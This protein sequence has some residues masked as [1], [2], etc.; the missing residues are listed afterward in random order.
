MKVDIIPIGNSKGIRI[1][2]ALLDQCGFDK[3]VYIAV[4]DH[5]LILSSASKPRHGWDHAFKAMAAAKDDE[6]LELPVS[7]FDQDEWQW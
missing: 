7:S 4:K 5:R 6:P 1:P 3:S 2:K